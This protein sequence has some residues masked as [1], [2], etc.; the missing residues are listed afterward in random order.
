MKPD[1]NIPSIRKRTAIAI[2]QHPELQ[3]GDE[4]DC[5]ISYDQKWRLARVTNIYLSGRAKGLVVKLY[6]SGFNW[7]IPIKQIYWQPKLQRW[8]CIRAYETS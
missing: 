4:V 1:N 7:N 6:N 3:V 2:D 8:E 5:R